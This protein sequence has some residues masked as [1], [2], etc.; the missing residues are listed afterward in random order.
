MRWLVTLLV[1]AGCGKSAPKVDDKVARDSAVVPVELDAAQ[2]DAQ[3]VID[4]VEEIDKPDRPRCAIKA[5][6]RG[7]DCKIIPCRCDDG[8]TVSMGVCQD[9]CCASE[10]DTCEGACD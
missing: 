10:K 9:G 8:T 5:C 3:M 1:L 6:E 4:A 7:E 2:V